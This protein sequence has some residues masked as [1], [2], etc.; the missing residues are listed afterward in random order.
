MTIKD[1]A[2]LAGV[3]VSTVSKIVNG[4]DQNIN[5]DTRQRVLEIVKKYNYSPYGMIQQNKNSK[6]FLIGVLLKDQTESNLFLNGILNAAQEQNYNLLVFHS[7]NDPAIELQHL[8]SICK[9]NLD[10]ILW[11][12]VNS[13]SLQHVELLE[14]KNICYQFINSSDI[15]EACCIDFSAIGY[16]ATKQLISHKHSDIACLLKPDSLRSQLVFNGFRQCLYDHH[17]DFKDTMALFSSDPEYFEKILAC[18]FSGIVS[19]HFSNAI[20]LYTQMSRQHFFAPSDL[21][22]ISL[23]GDI[24]ESLCFPPLSYVQIP[25]YDFGAYVC[26]LLI[27]QCEKK[28]SSDISLNY[29]PD[30]VLSDESSISFP[31]AL[32]S[33]KTIVV[34]SINT[35][36]TF[37]VDKIPQAGKTTIIQNHLISVGGKGA[38]QAIGVAKLHKEVC[39]LGNVGKDLSSTLILN[40]LEEEHVITQG[41]H[42][43][44]SED[45]GKAY[46]YIEKQ[47][48]SSISVLSGANST[49]TPEIILQQRQLFHNVGYCLLSSE[50]PLE[51]VLCAAELTTQ[52]GGKNIFK[53]AAVKQIPDALYSVVDIFIPNKR[54]A[55]LLCPQET[56]L[57]NQATY[58]LSRGVKSVIITLGHHGCYYRTSDTEKYYPA[59]SVTATDT[60]GGADAFI[61]ALSAYLTDGYSVDSAIQIAAIAASYC[62]SRQGVVPALVDRVTLE[63]NITDSRPYLLEAKHI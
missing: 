26:T 31:T 38:N 28:D 18:N 58:F 45:T 13:S 15:S 24:R 50:V 51:T 36:M 16:F 41:I 49:L 62:V 21:S 29:S 44:P 46:I 53:P 25:F 60:T 22:L 39:L 12:P 6:S 56:T 32:R 54:E 55:S 63:T 47:G 17:I 9:N 20:D 8:T 4:K 59:E 11:E 35:D 34:G 27:N 2:R 14:Q 7:A 23:K 42:R 30:C 61:S 19:S 40:T 52:N 10:G 3:S 43:D 33:K 37:Q 5:P 48:E 57:E 1:I